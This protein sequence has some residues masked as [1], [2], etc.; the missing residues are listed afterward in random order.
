VRLNYRVLGLAA[1]FGGIAMM[2]AVAL[3]TFISHR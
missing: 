3:L 1:M 2:A